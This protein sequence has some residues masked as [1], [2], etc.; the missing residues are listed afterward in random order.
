MA[1]RQAASVQNKAKIMQQPIE[2]TKTKRIT[3]DCLVVFFC[4]IVCDCLQ[5]IHGIGHTLLNK[6][7]IT[8]T[9]YRSPLPGPTSNGLSNAETTTGIFF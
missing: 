8:E 3:R 1:L 2:G 4:L 6:A 5:V 9:D 7:I